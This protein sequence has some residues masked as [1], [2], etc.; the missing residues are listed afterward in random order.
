FPPEKRQVT[1]GQFMSALMLGAVFSGPIG[2][3]FG[4]LGWRIMFMALGGISLLVSL[5]LLRAAQSEPKPQRDSNKPSASIVAGYRVILS[6]PNSIVVN[7]GIFLEGL[8]LFG[9]LIFLSIAMQENFQMKVLYAGLLLSCY[10]IGGLIYS[11]TAKAIVAR[12]HQWQMALLG[13]SL[14]M[15]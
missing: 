12:L 9:G 11:L 7:L 6:N 3:I 10:G 13:G 5:A 14:L 4:R 8:F 2:G 1:L 15:V